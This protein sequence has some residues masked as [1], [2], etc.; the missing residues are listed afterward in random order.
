[1]GVSLACPDWWGKLQAG[2]TPMPDLDLDPVLA[3]IAVGVFDKLRVP[4]IPGQP[5]FGAVGGGWMRDIVAAVFAARDPETKK[6]ALN[7]LFLLVPKKN[8]KTTL[9]AALGIVWL[10]INR[11]PNVSGVIIGPTQDIADT[12]FSAAA[13][14]ISLDDYLARRFKVIDHKKLIQD[15]HTDPETRVRMN[16][17]LRIK[18]FDPKVVTGT[19]P[20]FSV[21]DELHVMAESHHADRVIGQIRGGMITNPDAIMVIITTQSETPPSGV[22]KDELDYARQVRDGKVTQGVRMLPVLYEYPIEVQADEKKPWRD[23]AMWAPVLPNLGRSVQIDVLVDQYMTE[24]EKGPHAEARW[25]GQHLNIQI[26]LGLHA[27]RWP[28][29]LYWEAARMPGLTL[30]ELIGRSEVAVI[31]VDGGGL[32]DLASLA[33]IGRCRDTHNW[34]HWVRAWADPDVFDLRKEIAGRLRT[35]EKQGDLVVRTQTDT[36]MT[37]MADICERLWRAGLL[38]GQA[39]VGL[40]AWGVSMLVEELGRRGIGGDMVLGVGQGWKL[41]DAVKTLPRKIKDRT[42]RHAGQDL[43][44]WAVGNAKQ[45]LRNSNEIVTKQAAGRGKIDPLMATFNAAMLMLRNP[46]AAISMTPWDLDPEFR[47]TA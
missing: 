15:L 26:G 18:S 17:K 40:D 34:L 44:G 6:R 20:A 22:F 41:Q 39:A 46:Q 16:T 3:E 13:A 27:D 1:M 37:E 23:P 29:A 42:F 31:G 10:V 38:P 11:I 9:A 47:M 30:D 14:M 28:G 43:M 8:A 4:D 7:E 19:I 12:C 25:L 35:F 45:E 21:L 24:R 5:A 36:D 2:E 33:V 32:D